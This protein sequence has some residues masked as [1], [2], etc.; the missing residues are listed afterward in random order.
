MEAIFW[1]TEIVFFSE[2]FI[3]AIGNGFMLITNPLLLFRAFFCYWTPF[4]KSNLGQFLN[5]NV[6]PAH[7]NIFLDFCRY[8][9]EWKQLFPARGNGVFIKS[10]IKTSAYGFSVNFKQCA[11]IQR[12]PFCCWK[13]LLKLGV[14][15]FSS[16]FS[17]PN[18]GCSFPG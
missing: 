1:S 9:C 15:Q 13:A 3:L 7:W 2:S 14:N 17:V 4:L 18:S 10:F 8:F 5:K 11:F 6:N 16:I 12:F